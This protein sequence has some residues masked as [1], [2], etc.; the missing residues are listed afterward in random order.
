MTYK[1]E[2]IRRILEFKKVLKLL[3]VKEGFDFF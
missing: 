3:Q 1:I 2:D